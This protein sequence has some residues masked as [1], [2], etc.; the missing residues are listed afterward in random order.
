MTPDL[1]PDAAPLHLDLKKDSALTVHWRDGAA[2]AY[3]LDFLRAHCPCA[4]CRDRRAKTVDAPPPARRTPDGS[5]SLNVLPAGAADGPLAV[6]DAELVGNYAL[7]LTWTDGHATGIY[8]FR[9]LRELAADLPPSPTP[10][11]RT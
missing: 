7:R 1:P 5:L 8:S 4:A 6:R 2:S 11:S 3:P 10:L 9:L